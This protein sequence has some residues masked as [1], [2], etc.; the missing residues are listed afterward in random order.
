MLAANHSRICMMNVD[1]ST[2]EP[3]AARATDAAASASGAS[4]RL[5]I[6][7]TPEQGGV[8]FRVWAPTARLAEVVVYA[9]EGER[10]HAL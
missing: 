3:R 7:A 9:Q 10:A 6:G 2:R 5:T 1:S 8:R 4:W